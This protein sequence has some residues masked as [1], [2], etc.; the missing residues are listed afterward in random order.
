MWAKQLK[1]VF[2]L[3]AGLVGVVSTVV[4]HHH[5][6]NGAVCLSLFDPHHQA[7]HNESESEVPYCDDNCMNRMNTTRTSSVD[8]VDLLRVVPVQISVGS[9]VLT[10]LSPFGDETPLPDFGIYVERLHSAVH[11]QA[12]SL[13]AP[14]V[15]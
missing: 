9:W 13:R 14:P 8:I 12:L 15:V 3:I 10:I 6:E 2:L 4:P 11:L 5:H 1:I 7:Q